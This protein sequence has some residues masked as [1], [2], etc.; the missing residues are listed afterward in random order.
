MWYYHYTLYPSDF[1]CHYG[2]KGMKWGVR[3][4]KE[5]LKYNRASIE[6]VVNRTLSK[7]TV[8]S[9]S[10]IRLT[11]ISGHALDRIQFGDDHGNERKVT[12]KQ[13]LDAVKNPLHVDEIKIDKK[14]RPS[15]KHFGRNATVSVNPDTGI[16]ATVWQTGT[17]TR[18]KYGG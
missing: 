18:K 13:I 4:S 5:Q 17:K 8:V 9:P 14:G 15:Q 11:G 6:A 1:L 7:N 2:V 10:G 3:R 16:V 12:A